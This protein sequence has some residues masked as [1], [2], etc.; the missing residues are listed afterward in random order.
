MLPGEYEAA[1]ALGYRVDG[2]DIVD[3]NYFG[4]KK[5]VPKT[6]KCCVGPE[7]PTNHY[8]TIDCWFYPVWPQLKDEEIQMIVGKLCP[9]KGFALTEV[10]E[11]AYAIER[12]T[13]RLITI[14]EIKNFLMHAEMI[15]YEQLEY[16]S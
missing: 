5:V 13:E 16:K 4:G 1:I 15:G 2:Y 11:Q 7:M 8:K 6:K 14:S 9:L 3:D 10:K 12:Y